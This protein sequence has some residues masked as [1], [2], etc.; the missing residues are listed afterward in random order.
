M[1]NFK[2]EPLS[3]AVPEILTHRNGRIR[4]VSCFKPLK[5]RVIGHIEIE[6]KYIM[7]KKD[8]GTVPDWKRLRSSNK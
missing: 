4:N 7:K 6:R 2:P 3:T 1:R 8:W 5:F